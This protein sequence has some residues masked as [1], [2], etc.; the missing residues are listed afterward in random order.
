[1]DRLE[2]LLASPASRRRWI[3]SYI[4]TDMY[5]RADSMFLNLIRAVREIP[6]LHFSPEGLAALFEKHGLHRFR[7][8]TGAEQVQELV[9][10]AG[11]RRFALSQDV[12]EAES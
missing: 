1:M 5:L 3:L 7:S 9:P 11:K 4:R 6:R 8:W 10:Q 12:A 2:A